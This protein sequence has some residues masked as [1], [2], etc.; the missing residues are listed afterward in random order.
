MDIKAERRKVMIRSGISFNKISNKQ[1]QK[2]LG[3]PLQMED[4]RTT[5][6]ELPISGTE[7]TRWPNVSW[8]Q[9]KRSI[10]EDTQPAFGG[11]AIVNKPQK[12]LSP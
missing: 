12:Y 6:L 2:G 3:I 9:L 4:T 8:L 7:R 1:K 11:V 10:D 5:S